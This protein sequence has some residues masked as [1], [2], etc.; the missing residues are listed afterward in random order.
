MSQNNT[1][2]SYSEKPASTFFKRRNK[3]C[4]LVDVAI[5]YTDVKL[6]ARFISERGRIL[7]RRIT[8]VSAIKQRELRLA[9]TR[10]RI[11]ALLPFSSS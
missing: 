11:L 5:H 2:S 1:N 4:P 8:G 9:I 3:G 7:P 10:A 6:L